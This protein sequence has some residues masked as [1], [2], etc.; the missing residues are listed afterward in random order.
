MDKDLFRERL[1]SLL[2]KK[3]IKQAQL[4]KLSGISA[5]SISDWL[6]GKYSPKQDK[7]EILANILKV[8]SL[9]LAGISKI[10]TPL[11]TTSTTNISNLST[12][13]NKIPLLGE[14]CAG[15]GIF[16]EENFE[17]YIYNDQIKGADFALT[18]KG[19]SMTE[20]GI[21]EGD[22]VF[23]K[24]TSLVRNGAIAAVLLL[25]SNEA[26]IKKFYKKDTHVLLQPCNSHYE[27][28]ITKDVLILGEC[29]GIFRKF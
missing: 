24:K 4:S 8:N 5:S 15:D 11:S 21:F 14:I 6:K 17:N 19:D 10:R 3:N 9:W 16:V 29:I 1:S 7:I 12:K 26:T 25:D 2:K 23:I 28:I 20:A 27:P 22:V 13:I 18:V